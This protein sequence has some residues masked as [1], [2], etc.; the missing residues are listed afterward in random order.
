MSNFK[1]QATVVNAGIALEM[2]SNIPSGKYAFSYTG[3]AS[4]REEGDMALYE[5]NN[6]GSK[7]RTLLFPTQLKLKAGDK[8]PIS[9]TVVI[10]EGKVKL[11]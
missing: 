11:S 9:G 1:E 10:S 2:T 5:L 3:K 7:V 6:N 8:W 4:E